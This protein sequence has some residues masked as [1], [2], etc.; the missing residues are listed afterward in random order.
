MNFGEKLV[1][2]D[3][4]LLVMSFLEAAD[5]CVCAAVNVHFG[6]LSE[7]DNVWCSLC[8][9]DW[10]LD[11]DSISKSKMVS[12]QDEEGVENKEPDAK[13]AKRITAHN[14]EILQEEAIDVDQGEEETNRDQQKINPQRC[15]TL[16]NVVNELLESGRKKNL[17]KLIYREHCKEFGDLRREY[18]KCKT[19]WNKLEAYLVDK[20]PDLVASLQDGATRQSIDRLEKEFFNGKEQEIGFSN[21]F[22]CIY[23]MHDGQK[24]GSSQGLFGS[25]SFYDYTA[26]VLMYPLDWMADYRRRMLSHQ[27]EDLQWIENCI[28]VA[29]KRKVLILLVVKDFQLFSDHYQYKSGQVIQLPNSGAPFVLADSYM[30]WFESF[31]ENLTVKHFYDIDKSGNIIRYP[32]SAEKGSDTTTRGVRIQCNALLIPEYS[33]ILP[34]QERYFFAYRIRMSMAPDESK[35]LSCILTT[36]KWL[37]KDANG[38]EDSIEGPGVIGLY[39]VMKPGATFSYC[40]CTQAETRTGSMEGYFTMKNLNTGIEFQARID[41]FELNIQNHL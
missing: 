37:V 24:P 13:R 20:S 3:V 23:R 26:N 31:V 5:L 18:K 22:K 35:S 32:N 10:L 15:L 12:G 4:L 14:D 17:Y 21:E 7:S 1:A 28:P 25:Y 40:S 36:R 33:E 39:P 41:P 27:I 16:I 6:S 11:I 9:S 2:D 29:G 30:E 38:L 8:K 34:Y 19:L